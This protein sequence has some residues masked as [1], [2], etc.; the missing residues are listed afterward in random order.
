MRELKM[1]ISFF[2]II[3]INVDNFDLE[4]L[5]NK[6]YLIVIIGYI[7]GFLGYLFYFIFSFLS[8]YLLST[9]I[10]FFLEYFNRFQHFD[11]L[12][13]VGDALMACKSRE[14]K[15]KILKDSKIGVG[16]IALSSFYFFI[17]IFS[18]SYI[19][20][21][22]PLYILVVEVL[23]RLS[24]LST[25]VFGTPF[26]EGMAKYFVKKA[27][28]KHLTLGLI[29]A[30][31]TIFI[32][33]NHR[34]VALLIIISVLL[35]FFIAKLAKKE[36]GGVNGDVLGFSNEISRMLLYL[37]IVIIYSMNLNIQI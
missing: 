26:K 7:S 3:P 18:L 33:N 16:A 23:S 30:L 9:L 36:F 10:L 1:L 5:A 28:E 37:A 27:N 34:I 17:T 31:P 21:I 15:I 11:G 12:L 2:T 19:L 25:A 24:L 20:K 13:D 6:F 4:K 14:E 8:I 32:L 22:Q 35:G 29:L